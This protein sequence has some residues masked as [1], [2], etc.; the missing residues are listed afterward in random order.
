MVVSR[1]CMSSNAAER[2]VH[3]VAIGRPNWSSTGAVRPI[4]RN[5]AASRQHVAVGHLCRGR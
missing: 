3:P 4:A 5:S 2:G 1:L